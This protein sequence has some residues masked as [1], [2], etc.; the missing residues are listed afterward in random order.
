M[1]QKKNDTLQSVASIIN[2]GWAEHHWDHVKSNVPVKYSITYYHGLILKDLKL[3][4]P[5]I[6]RVEMSYIL[7]QGYIRTRQT[8]CWYWIS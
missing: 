1:K 8:I 7:Y 5:G 3:V 4:I 6:L 2:N